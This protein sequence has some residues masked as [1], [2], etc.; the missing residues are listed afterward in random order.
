[1]GIFFILSLPPPPLFFFRPPPETTGN[2]A[3][4]EGTFVNLQPFPVSDKGFPISL[5][6]GVIL[7]ASLIDLQKAAFLSSI[8]EFSLLRREKTFF[9]PYHGSWILVSPFSGWGLFPSEVHATLGCLFF[10]ILQYNP[11]FF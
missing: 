9:F 5:S 3:L 7:A 8:R 10:S 1:M 2:S 11:I 4:K 6:Y